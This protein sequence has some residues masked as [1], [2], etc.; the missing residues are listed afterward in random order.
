MDLGWEK[1]ISEEKLKE[2]ANRL[3]LGQAVTL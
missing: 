3:H 2:V 1:M